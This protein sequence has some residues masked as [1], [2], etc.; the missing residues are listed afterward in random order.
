MSDGHLRRPQFIGEPSGGKEDR[1]MLLRAIAV[2]F[3]L[4]MLASLNGVFREVVMTPRLGEPLAQAVSSI[5]LCGLVLLVTW[6]TLGWIHPQSSRD[7]LVV[8]SLWVALTL[9]FEFLVG[10]YVQHQPWATLLADYDVRRG[11]IG[12]IVVLIVTFAAPLWLGRVRGF[13]TNDG[14]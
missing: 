2:W 12:M 1:V 3:G 4:V 13:V 9:A 8:G 5:L 11:R 6:F 10:H 14:P 7:A